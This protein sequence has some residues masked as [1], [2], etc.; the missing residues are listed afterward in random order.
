MVNEVARICY[1]HY[2]YCIYDNSSSFS[3]V[4]GANEFHSVARIYF[5]SN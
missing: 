1:Y 2:K 3:G 5:S 4:L